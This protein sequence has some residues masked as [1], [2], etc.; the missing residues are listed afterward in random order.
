MGT[1]SNTISASKAR[2]N[3]YFLL[4]EVSKKLRRFTITRRG[5]AKVVL[6]HPDEVASWEETMDIVSD[7]KLVGEILKSESE[8]EAGKVISEKKLLKELGIS[9]TDLKK[10]ES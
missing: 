1:L 7:N 5:E 10:N 3:F 4:E 9:G 2:S 6:M 8:R